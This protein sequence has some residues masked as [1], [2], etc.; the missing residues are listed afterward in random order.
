MA[1]SR[2]YARA[3]CVG[4]CVMVSVAE[5]LLLTLKALIYKEL[6]TFF[7]SDEKGGA[8]FRR[9]GELVGLRQNPD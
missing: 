4:V 7:E 6:K 8:H 2:G 3:A 9:G 1:T 5:L